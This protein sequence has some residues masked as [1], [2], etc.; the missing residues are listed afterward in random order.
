MKEVA[1]TGGKIVIHGH[2]Y[3][4]SRENPWTGLVERERS[5]APY[6][7]WNQR[8]CDEC[9]R[10]HTAA[11]ILD[12][13]DRIRRTI[14]TYSRISC[15]FGPTLLAWLERQ[16]PAVYA[17]IISADRQAK[18]RFSG[19]GSAIAHPYHHVILPLL[20][21]RDK[22]TE[23]RW[24][25][26][27]FEDRFGRYPEGMWLPEMA[28]DY[29]T[30]EVLADHG[31]RFTVLAPHQVR[32]GPGNAGNE[33]GEIPPDR[34]QPFRCLLP[35]GEEIAIFV[36]DA[37]IGNEIAFGS[38]LE[39]GDRYAER[40]L[41]AASS[42]ALVHVAT[43]G[44]TFGHHRKFGEMALARCIERLDVPPS[45][46]TVY[47]E[48]LDH[49]P[50]LYEVRIVE[51][52]SWSCPHGIS[53]WKGGCDCTSGRHPGWSH[54][55]RGPLRSAL[56]DLSRLLSD[57]YRQH[58]GPLFTDPN[59]ARDDCIVL[60]RDPSPCTVRKFMDA[61]APGHL[62][63]DECRKG[64]ALLELSR[65]CLAMQLSCALFFDDIGDREPVQALRHAARALQIASDIT[66]TDF[67]AGFRSSLAAISGNRAAFPDADRVYTGC[68]LPLVL[69]PFQQAACFALQEICNGRAPLSYTDQESGDFIAIG[70]GHLVHDIS[71]AGERVRY[72]MICTGLESCLV[73]V[74]NKDDMLTQDVC[75]EISGIFRKQGYYAAAEALREVCFPP[76]FTLD[77]LAPSGRRQVIRMQL[78]RMQKVIDDTADDLFDR[79][80]RLENEVM[81]GNLCSP[82]ASR[83]AR[84]VLT[85]RMRLLLED[86]D[87]TTADLA[88]LAGQ[89]AG[90]DIQVDENELRIPAESFLARLTLT[91][92]AT[93]S[94]TERLGQVSD[95]LSLMAGIPIR[96][97][98]WRLQNLFL[99]VRDAPGRPDFSRNEPAGPCTQSGKEQFLAVAEMLGV[100]S[101]FS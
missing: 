60:F 76:P 10:P 56:A 82:C 4:P 80:T 48:F 97:R 13:E 50:P 89:C 64:C 16:E 39:N 94:N 57:V 86:P 30:L 3:Q 47:G 49:S 25:T 85:R 42:S 32:P 5:A 87:S 61:H 7:D 59:M 44:E 100:R 29:E 35:S 18:E 9:Y 8:I 58:A 88:E 66:G 98:L 34:R 101:G 93:P 62:S 43:D 65:Q 75:A 2:F 6:H 36:H 92:V 15:D 72:C 90:W 77:D 45:P 33:R 53:R 46:L 28:V 19:H 84:E 20:T 70:E 99:K 37:G 96:V 40:L 38:L 24:G 74:S 51:Q 14:P 63:P 22:T 83:L 54:A 67:S 73:G 41:S 81:D 1:V 78:C 79:Y 95:A 17:E 71:R 31:I 11:R 91:W 27:D 69:T 23:I 52:T 55:W 68:V 12:N 26:R 21:R